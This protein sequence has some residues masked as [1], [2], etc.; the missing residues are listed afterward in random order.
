MEEFLLGRIL[1]G[2]ELDIVDEQHVRVAV[3][4]VEFDRRAVADGRDQLVCEFVAFDVDDVHLRAVFLDFIKNRVEQ[5]RFAKSRIAV[6]KQRIVKLGGFRRDGEAGR[7]RKLVAGADDKRFER[8]LVVVAAFL[9]DG[10]GGCVG[11]VQL[12]FE[13]RRAENLGERLLQRV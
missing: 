5:V 1:A 13:V 10:L 11:G 6:N 3:A 12:D 7:V 8:V 4:V 2:D 9:F